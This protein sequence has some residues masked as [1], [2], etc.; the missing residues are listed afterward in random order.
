[1]PRCRGKTSKGDRC[2]LDANTDS[3]YCHHHEP[4]V[5]SAA[6]ETGGHQ[7]EP[8]AEPWTTEDW[9]NLTVGITVVVA[10]VVVL[11]GVFKIPGGRW[12]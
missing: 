6:S 3:F 9:W 5:A 7:D 11:R 4:E 12:L 1:M 8:E 2:K 10:T